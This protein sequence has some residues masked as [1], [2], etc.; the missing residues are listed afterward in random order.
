M[1]AA[2]ARTSFIARLAGAV[3]LSFVTAAG[4]FAACDVETRNRIVPSPVPVLDASA[5]ALVVQWTVD[6]VNVPSEC[7]T[8]NAAF[9]RLTVTGSNDEVFEVFQEDCRAF[10]A[11]ITLPAGNYEADAVL[12]D[13]QGNVVSQTAHIDHFTLVGNDEALRIIDLE[14]IAAN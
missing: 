2:I 3:L 1:A 8:R 9:L 7:D 13:G 6:G 14:P 10:T 12:I 5:G 11:N 4:I